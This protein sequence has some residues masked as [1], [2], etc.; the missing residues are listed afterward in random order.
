MASNYPNALDSFTDP[1]STSPLNS[2]SHSTLH[3]DVNDAI[4]KIEAYVPR[5]NFLYNGAMQVA[6]RGTST[7]SITTSGY[8]TADRWKFV[9]TAF[10]TWTQSVENDAPTGSGFRKSLKMLCTTATASPTSSALCV[11]QQLLEGQD[12]QSIC[13]GTSSAQQLTVSFWVKSNVT[14]TYVVALFDNDNN[15]SV[16]KTYTVSASGTWEYK[17]VTFPADTTGAFNNDNDN[18]LQ[19]VFG[20]GAG[21]SFTSG[22]LNQTWAAY[23]AANYMAGQ[24]NVAAATNNYWQV[25]GVQLN[26]GAVAAPFEFKDYGRELRECQRYYYRNS[27]RDATNGGHICAPGVVTGGVSIG[28]ATIILPVPLR[29]TPSSSNIS[30]SQVNVYDGATVVSLSSIALFAGGELA[31]GIDG[32]V[33]AGLTSFR[34]A[35]ILFAGSATAFIAIN[36]EL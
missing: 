22:T 23:S 17:T 29:A 14:G 33:P 27:N 2:P 30:Y 5:R 4:E 13:K 21:S 9:P 12:V 20:L 25:T 36:M 15:R 11:I 19:M 6:Q 10:G 35:I 26:L 3:A 1:L 16:G 31:I 7:A 34:P 18:S 8:Y 24:V 32:V 28:R